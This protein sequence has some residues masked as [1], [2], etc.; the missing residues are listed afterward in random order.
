MSAKNRRT[1]FLVNRKLQ[2]GMSFQIVAYVYLYLVLFAL[3][4]NYSALKTV[5]FGT[6][7][8]ADYIAAVE[9]LEVFVE[10]MVLPLILTFLCLWLHGILFSHRLAG[11]IYRIKQALSQA[12]SGNLSMD[13]KLRERD[14]FQDICDELNGL[15]GRLR[16][17]MAHCREL[18][19]R[20]ADAA[21]ALD[22]TG[23]LN[24]DTRSRLVDMA[25][26]TQELRKLVDG[27]KF[28]PD[29]FAADA[30]ETENALARDEV[31]AKS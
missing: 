5:V 19:G 17:D 22:S 13:V 4:A 18:S 1:R 7:G 28:V 2:L 26:A 21:E 3:L 11:P 31:P 20:L 24:A 12:R 6:G 23:E 25:N 15:C 29:G 30:S 10:V 8:D 27:Y 9:R 16:G 14:Y